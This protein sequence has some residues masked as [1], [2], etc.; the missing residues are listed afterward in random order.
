MVDRWCN[1]KKKQI[2]LNQK[3]KNLQRSTPFYMNEHLMLCILL[4]RMKLKSY[5]T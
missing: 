4:E 2:R 1:E 3:L 5:S